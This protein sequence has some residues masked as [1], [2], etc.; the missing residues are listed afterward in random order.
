MSKNVFEFIKFDRTRLQINRNEKKNTT[1]RQESK[2]YET[3]DFPPKSLWG[4]IS[5]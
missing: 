4:K 2:H 3:N 1:S 5:K